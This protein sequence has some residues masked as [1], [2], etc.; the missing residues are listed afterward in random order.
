MRSWFSIL[1]EEVIGCRDNEDVGL[2]EDEGDNKDCVEGDYGEGEVGDLVYCDVT[3]YAIEGSSGSEDF[4]LSDAPASAIK[5][6]AFTHSNLALTIGDS[7][8]PPA[9]ELSLRYLKPPPSVL[10][11]RSTTKY[12]RMGGCYEG[13]PPP[14][15]IEFRIIP[16]LIKK[17]SELQSIK[18]TLASCNTKKTLGNVEFANGEYTRALK[19]YGGCAEKANNFLSSFE[20]DQHDVNAVKLQEVLISTTNN[21]ALT[22]FKR[23]NYS[24]AKD[25]C[26]E[27]LKIEPK[28]SKATIRASMCCI[29]MGDYDEAKIAL[30]EVLKVDDGNIAARRALLLLKDRK[31]QY[32]RK[33]KE[34]G[35]RMLRGKKED[36]CGG[37]ESK[38]ER[39]IG[40]KR[41]WF[42]ITAVLAVF[43]S[44]LC[45]IITG[46]SKLVD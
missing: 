6:S 31:I 34:L 39:N 9:F 46:S 18:H 1:S 4:I 12:S 26:V 5:L 41:R 2:K 11:V 35:E 33:K 23:K 29:E 10:T 21:I 24:L 27:V 7:E 15:G 16:K 44:I 45:R 8:V 19:L 42:V 36:V 28:N 22:Q 17:S 37:A 30:G 14:L 25:A 13:A 3:G 43:V 38:Q 32:K 40:W 20:G